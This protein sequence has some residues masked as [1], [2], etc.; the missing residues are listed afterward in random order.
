MKVSGRGDLFLADDA[1]EVHL[2]TLEG[3]SVALLH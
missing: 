3:D 2:I 1:S